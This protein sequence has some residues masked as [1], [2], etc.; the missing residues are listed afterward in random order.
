MVKVG[1]ITDVKTTVKSRKDNSP[2]PAIYQNVKK[3]SFFVCSVGNEYQ[4]L[5]ERR[6]VSSGGVGGFVAS[7]SSVSAPFPLS[8][9]GIMRQGIK[10][11]KKKYIRV[12][13]NIAPNDYNETIYLGADGKV[14]NIPAQDWDAYFPVKS[15]SKKQASHGVKKE[16]EVV[17]RDFKQESIVYFQSGDIVWNNLG[18]QFLKLFN[19]ENV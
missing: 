19:L 4:P 13:F 16:N 9:N 3:L 1:S 15:E 12:Y 18:D 7:E 8:E 17:V 10:D 2:T 6:I 14:L 11:E 5:V